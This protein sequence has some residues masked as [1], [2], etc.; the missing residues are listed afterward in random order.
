MHARNTC[1]EK[2]LSLPGS[3]KAQDKLRRNMLHSNI[4]TSWLDIQPK[5][6]KQNHYKWLDG[7][8]FGKYLCNNK[9]TFFHILLTEEK[10]LTAH[11]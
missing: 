3:E 5:T 11:I 9:H 10:S 2:G 1:I 6:E 8:A 4:N 7:T